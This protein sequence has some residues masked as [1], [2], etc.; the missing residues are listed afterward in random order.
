MDA[1]WCIADGCGNNSES[2]RKYCRGHRKR[3]N[4][5][6]PVDA[7][8]RAWGTPPDDYLRAKARQFADAQDDDR[9]QRLAWKLLAWAAV[10]YFQSR[11]RQKV[12]STPET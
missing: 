3:D 2:G 8:L 12:P 4:Q 5:R 9:A 11:R 7:P 1:E 10:R 6:R